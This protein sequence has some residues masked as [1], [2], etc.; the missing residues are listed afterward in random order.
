MRPRPVTPSVTAGTEEETGVV[1]S[2]VPDAF[3]YR[4]LPPPACACHSHA[5]GPTHLRNACASCWGD[6][7]SDPAVPGTP[8]EAPATFDSGGISGGAGNG[9]LS[10]QGSPSLSQDLSAEVQHHSRYV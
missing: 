1:V 3:L 8:H 4:F 7:V 5:T 10:T 2:L 6:A 9:L